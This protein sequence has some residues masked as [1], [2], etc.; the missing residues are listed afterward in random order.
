MTVVRIGERVDNE[1]R[2]PTF[3]ERKAGVFYD[4]EVFKK[5]IKEV[6]VGLRGSDGILGKE[7]SVESDPCR[8]RVIDCLL[9]TSPSPRD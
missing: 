4:E 5:S 7:M 3:L 1:V 9:Y 6:T 8:M 2:D